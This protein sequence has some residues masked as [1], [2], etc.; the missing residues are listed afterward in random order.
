ME[1]EREGIAWLVNKNDP[2]FSD[3]T[4]IDPRG[5][6]EQSINNAFLVH[7]REMVDTKYSQQVVSF[8]DNGRYR[9]IILGLRQTIII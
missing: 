3:R 5:E 6:E 9:G 1:G 2:A 4:G 8:K 7:L